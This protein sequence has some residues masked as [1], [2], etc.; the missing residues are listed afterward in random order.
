MLIVISG[1]I[2]SGKDTVG[3]II[4]YLTSESSNKTG[5]RYR[6]FN[7]FVSKGG[8]STSRNFDHH[9]YSD[10]QIK[11]FADT[12][13]DMVCM[14]IGCTRKQ[15]EDH[16]FKDTELGEE[17][18]YYKFDGGIMI[19]YLN[20]GY[21]KG[22]EPIQYLFK[23]TPRLLLQ[24]LGTEC[25]RNI[26][27]KDIWVNAL[28]SKYTREYRQHPD[29]EYMEAK[30]YPN[31]I[32]TDMRFPN[33]KEAVEK[34][35]GIT[36]RVNREG[37]F[38]TTIDGQYHIK[39]EN[40]EGVKSTINQVLENEHP[41]ETSLDDSTFNYTIENNGTIEELVDKVREILIKE[42]IITNG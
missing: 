30:D 6:D 9:Y 5:K 19:P 18:W 11:K 36:I 7:T 24:L 14:L 38:G 23:L 27:H 10:F 31:W 12:L 28:F 8:G 26:I 2:G 25:G 41:S 42:K 13:K 33:E 39:E 20:N 34:R 32:I 1:K 15:L 40:L 4:Q 35:R 21:T 3:K 37:N 16:E 29:I 22:K 17:W